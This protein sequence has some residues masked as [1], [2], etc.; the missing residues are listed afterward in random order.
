MIIY[1][2]FTG[3]VI[4]AILETGS[5][6]EQWSKEPIYP[7]AVLNMFGLVPGEDRLFAN[8]ILLRLADAFRTGDNHTRVCV[9]KVFLLELK[10]RRKNGK[11]YNGILAKR[12]VSNHVEL[13]KRVKIV[14]DTGDAESRG[15]AL[16]LLGCWADFAKD[17][18]EIR[19]M[20]L[21]SLRSCHILEVR[22][23]SVAY[24]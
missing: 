16:R 14:F 2:I 21:S 3:R 4:E 19:Y 22:S 6:L 13:L 15:L 24:I 18:A 7:I 12:R 11:R 5:R 17:S 1:I 9:L 20:V 23:L 10:H 8:A